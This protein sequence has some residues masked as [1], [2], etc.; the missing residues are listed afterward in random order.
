[1]KIFILILI[2]FSAAVSLTFGQQRKEFEEDTKNVLSDEDS[3]REIVF[4]KILPQKFEVS[5]SDEYL[6]DFYLDVDGGKDP[7]NDLLKKINDYYSDTGIKIMKISECYIS[8]SLGSV[9]LNVLTEKQGVLFSVSK[10]DWENKDEVKVTA[11]SY[12]G[13][14]GS[15]S[16]RYT[17]TR[18][19]GKW[20]ITNAE[21]CVVS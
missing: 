7:S 15:N 2:T 4:K 8:E 10:I 6:K 20:E 3:I 21:S 14:L 17:L 11:G 13:N 18:R 5:N 16:C 1:M 9:V 19:V 12:I